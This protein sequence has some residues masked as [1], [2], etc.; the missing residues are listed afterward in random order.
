MG[1]LAE[2]STIGPYPYRI[3]RRLGR[4][5]GAMADVYLAS[6]TETIDP[7]AENLVVLK[8]ARAGE[9]DGDFYQKTLENE[10][11]RL[12]RL[13]HPGVVRIY[14]IQKTGLR[15]LPYMAQ[16]TLPN[17]PWFSVMEYLSGDSLT[18]LLQK[19]KQLDIGLALEIARSLAVILDYLHSL[20]QVHLDIKPENILFRTPIRA[21][22]DLQPVLIDFGIARTKG[23]TG[24][25]AGTVQWS[26][27]ERILYVREARPPETAVRPHP[28]MDIYALGVLLYRMIAGRLPFEGRTRESITSAI[29]RG[30]PTAPSTYQPLVKP[31]LDALTLQAF[32]ADPVRRPKA[33]ELARALEELAIRLEYRPRYGFV[34]AKP[35]PAPPLTGSVNHRARLA[36]AGMGAL[37]LIE[38]TLL[39]VIAYTSKQPT[40][41]TRIVTVSTTSPIASTEAT[42]NPARA[43]GAP[44]PT[45]TPKPGPGTNPAAPATVPPTSTPASI[46]DTPAPPTLLTPPNTPKPIPRRPGSVTLVSPA[47][48]VT[49]REVQFSWRSGITLESDQFYEVVFWESGKDPMTQSFGMSDSTKRT[50]TPVVNLAAL[51]KADHP[52]NLS[53]GTTY[54]WGVR[55]VKRTKPGD[56]PVRMLTGGRRITYSGP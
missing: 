43:T 21:G 10:V 29:L 40:N 47:D 53:P 34:T 6:A 9:E 46:T 28:S 54:L 4:S 27:P 11:E 14:P 16:A 44:L 19:Q 31:E 17:K 26:S 39:G 32:S 13:K 1:D 12:R 5:Q 56:I 7:D 15:N 20:D 3:I 18:S 33:D 50:N 8:M 55:L 51:D 42:T 41:P 38:S 22:V 36:I 23:Q 24:L 35:K 2:G 48:A 30:Q 25:E 37:I 45:S 49:V 52:L